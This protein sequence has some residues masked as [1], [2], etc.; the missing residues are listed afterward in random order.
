MKRLLILFFIIFLISCGHKKPIASFHKL[1]ISYDSGWEQSFSIIID[2]IGKVLYSKGRWHQSFFSAQL[3]ERDLLQLDSAYQRTPFKRY[4]ESY[5]QDIT[6]ASSFQIILPDFNNK[7]IYVYGAGPARLR[8]FMNFLCEI[9]ERLTLKSID[10]V[11]VFESRK[12]M[13]V[14]TP[15][16]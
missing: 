1:D 13:Q 8:T 3:S 4:L 16:H 15:L 7:R 6:D 14:P 12:G 11:V 10:S 5:T 9:S 2:S